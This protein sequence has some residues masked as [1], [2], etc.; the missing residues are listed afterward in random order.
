MWSKTEVSHGSPSTCPGDTPV[1][2]SSQGYPCAFSHPA[3]FGTHVAPLRGSTPA[4][5]VSLYEV[6]NSDHSSQ[7]TGPSLN[8]SGTESQHHTIHHN[9]ALFCFNQALI[10]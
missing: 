9:E 8:G 4:Q 6:V 1:L 10:G 7:W 3:P 2:S 5:I